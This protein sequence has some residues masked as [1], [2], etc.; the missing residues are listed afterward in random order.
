MLNTEACESRLCDHHDKEFV[1]YI[2]DSCRYGIDIGY[3]SL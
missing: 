1:K 3:D 2:V